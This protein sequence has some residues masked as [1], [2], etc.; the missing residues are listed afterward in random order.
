LRFLFH[1][2]NAEEVIKAREEHMPKQLD[3][4][5]T[6]PEEENGTMEMKETEKD[7][8]FKNFQ[9][10]VVGRFGVT[11]SVFLYLLDNY[12]EEQSARRSELRIVRNTTNRS[13]RTLPVSSSTP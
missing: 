10:D 2:K 7:R 4:S 6:I 13:N 1:G 9:D 3:I 12:N 5:F 8:L 11:P